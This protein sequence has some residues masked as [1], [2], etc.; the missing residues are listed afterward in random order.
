M[1][2]EGFVY[3]S[4]CHLELVN[5]LCLLQVHPLQVIAWIDFIKLVT[6]IVLFWMNILPHFGLVSHSNTLAA[7]YGIILMHVYAIPGCYLTII[8]GVK[9][10]LQ[11]GFKRAVHALDR[12]FGA[13]AVTCRA[14][15]EDADSCTMFVFHDFSLI[16][17]CVLPKYS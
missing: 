14:E 15:G 5:I 9:L 1:L 17:F 4:Y 10:H 8:A 2:S 16:G 3:R 13:R 7:F 6:A 11:H 12:G